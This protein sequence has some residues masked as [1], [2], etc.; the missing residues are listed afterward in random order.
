MTRPVKPGVSIMRHGDSDP[1]EPN[2]WIR[3]KSI[4][5]RKQT[6][7]NPEMI[8]MRT[9]KTRKTRSSRKTDRRSDPCHQEFPEEGLIDPVAGMAL[10][11]VAPPFT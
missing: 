3:H 9:E 11:G 8:P 1:P 10:F 6:T 2:K 4:A 7:A 5:K